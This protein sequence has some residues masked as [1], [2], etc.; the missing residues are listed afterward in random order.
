MNELKNLKEDHESEI[1]PKEVHLWEVDGFI[2]ICD[3]CRGK[4]KELIAKYDTLQHVMYS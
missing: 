2:K 3:L 4:F 1:S